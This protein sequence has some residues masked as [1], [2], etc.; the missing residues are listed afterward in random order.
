MYTIL[1]CDDNTLYSSEKEVIMHR[2]KLVDKLRFIVH[3]TYKDIDMTD[4]SVVME[5]LLPVSKKYKSEHLILSEERYK[6]C[7]LQYIL[8]F[9]TNIT[10]EAGKV[11][12]QLTFIKT[13]LDENGKGIQRVRKTSP[14]AIN[15]TPIMAWS[16]I[17]P[18]EALTSLDQRILYQDAQIRALN[19]LANAF[20]SSM[21]DNLV[22]DST[23]E[24]L[25]L[26]SKGNGVGDKVSVRDMIDDGIPVVD[27]DSTS[28]NDTNVGTGN[29]NGCDCNHD[30]DCEN[31][32]VEFGYI[33]NF[34]TTEKPSENDVIEF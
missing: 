21:V 32:V 26:T 11:E 6:D 12:V 4:T 14:T 34:D 33:P 19:D 28:G 22:Y 23:D 7:Y 5:Y 9:D 16:D 1:V 8:P 17:I 2:S 29:E 3:S 20:D 18:D 15:I 27:L 13:E 24:T 10:S 30:C 25:Q 31:N